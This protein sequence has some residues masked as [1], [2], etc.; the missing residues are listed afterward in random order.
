MSG[1]LSRVR[2]FWLSAAKTKGRPE[3][4]FNIDLQRV[5]PQ[6]ESSFKLDP[7]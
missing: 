1:S 4:A 3:P 7:A 6:K 5:D 2:R